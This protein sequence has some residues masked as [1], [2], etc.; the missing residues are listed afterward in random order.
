M[1]QLLGWEREAHRRAARLSEPE[2]WAL[3][4]DPFRRAVVQALDPK[5]T[6]ELLADLERVCAEAI[7]S[8]AGRFLVGV[9]RPLA[10]R[11]RLTRS[12]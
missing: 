7:A 1:R 4:R 6:L 11:G 10:D 3:A 12:G 9:S 5:G 2:V 8:Q